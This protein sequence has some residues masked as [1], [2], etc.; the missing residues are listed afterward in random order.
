MACEREMWSPGLLQVRFR[1]VDVSEL[2]G[3]LLPSCL[4]EVSVLENRSWSC[5]NHSPSFDHR[6]NGG[7]KLHWTILGCRLTEA[8]KVHQCPLG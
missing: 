5:S 3:L 7:S 2:R 6:G 8:K 1:G 4:F